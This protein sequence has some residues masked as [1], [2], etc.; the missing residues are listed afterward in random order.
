MLALT[1][2]DTFGC[3]HYGSSVGY[4]TESAEKRYMH[5]S[6]MR[7]PIDKVIGSL[8]VLL[9]SKLEFLDRRGL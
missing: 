9:G 6:S 2:N 1:Q 5:V 3:C 7:A 8:F 4:K